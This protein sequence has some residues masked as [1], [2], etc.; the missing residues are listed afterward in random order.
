MLGTVTHLPGSFVTYHSGSHRFDPFPFR[1]IQDPFTW[2]NVV[3]WYF[4][5]EEFHAITHLPV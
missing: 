5:A 3:N 2:W 4:A 1:A